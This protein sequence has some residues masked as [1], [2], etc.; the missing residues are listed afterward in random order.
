MH[1]VFADPKTDVA[2]IKIDAPPEEL[3]AGRKAFD[4]AGLRVTSGAGPEI[5][6][7]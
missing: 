1:P 7:G 5:I 2:V 4:D 3:R 6:V